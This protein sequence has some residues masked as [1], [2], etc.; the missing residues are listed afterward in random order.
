MYDQAQTLRL[1]TKGSRSKVNSY[2]I[3]DIE[4]AGVKKP[5]RFEVA[6]VYYDVII[7]DDFLRKYD[8]VVTFN[9]DEVV[10]RQPDPIQETPVKKAERAPRPRQKK[11][12]ATGHAPIKAQSKLQRNIGEAHDFDQD[13]WDD[14]DE[15][16][17]H[18][19][20]MTTMDDTLTIKTREIRELENRATIPVYPSTGQEDSPDYEPTEEDK[21]RYKMWLLFTFVKIFIGEGDKLP[22]PPMRAVMHEIPYIDK[23]DPPRP[24]RHYKVADAMMDKWVT[25]K[26]QHVEAGLWIPASTKNADPMMPILKKDGKARPVV[27]LRARNANTVKMSIPAVDADYIRS[28]IATNKYHVELDLK[29]AFQQLRIKPSDVWKTAFTSIHGVYTTPVAQQGDTNSPATLARMISYVYQ[30]LLG[31]QMEAYADNIF[32]VGNT[33]KEIRDHTIS[34]L[35]RSQVHELCFSTSSLKVCPEWVEVLGMDCQFGT[36]RMSQAHKDA[37]LTIAKPTT[38]VHLQR[39][40]GSVE[41]SSRYFPHLAEIVA[42]LTNLVGDAPWTWSAAQDIAFEETKK[43]IDDAR[44]LTVIRQEELAPRDTDPI[45]RSAPPTEPVTNPSPGKYILLQCDASSVGTSA[46][47]TYGENWWNALPVYHHSRKLTNTQLSYPTHEIELLAIFEGFQKFH[48]ILLGRKVT[49]ITENESLASFL[50]ARQMNE[51]QARVYNFISQFDFVI[52]HIESDWNKTPDMFSRQYEDDNICDSYEDPNLDDLDTEHDRDDYLLLGSRL[53]S[54]QTETLRRSSRLAQPRQTEQTKTPAVETTPKAKV[55]KPKPKKLS[56]KENAIAARLEEEGGIPTDQA[57]NLDPQHRDRTWQAATDYLNDPFFKKIVTTVDDFDRYTLSADGALWQNDEIYGDRLCIAAGTVDGR[58]VRELVLEHVHEMTVHTGSR[59]MLAHAAHHYWWPTTSADIEEYCKTCEACQVSKTGPLQTIA[60]DF[61]GPLVKAQWNGKE[62][63][64]LCNWIDTFTG[65]TISVPCEQTITAKGCA[66]LFFQSVF[67]HWGIPLQIVSD[68]D[69]RW[70]SDLWRSMFEGLG[71]TLLLS[72]SFHPQTNGRIERMHRDLNAMMR[73]IVNET[74]TNWPDQLPSSCRTENVPGWA[75]PPD[76]TAAGELID[77]AMQRRS[78]ARDTILKARGDQA[79]IANRKRKPDAQPQTAIGELFL[80]RTANFACAPDRPRK[81]TPPW[82]GPFK[83]VAFTPAT[84][85]YTLELSPRYAQ[86]RLHP[87]FHASQV[88]KWVATDE[89][90]FP[91]RLFNPKPLFPIDGVTMTDNIQTDQQMEV[92]NRDDIEYGKYGDLIGEDV[93][94]SATQPTPAPAEAVQA[95]PAPVTET[96]AD[97]PE[98]Q[99]TAPIQRSPSPDFDEPSYDKSITVASLKNREEWSEILRL[100]HR[101]APAK[102]GLGERNPPPRIKNVINI[103][104][105]GTGLRY[106]VKYS[107]NKNERSDTL[108]TTDDMVRDLWDAYHA[109]YKTPLNRWLDMHMAV[110]E[111]T[112]FE[113]LERKRAELAET[114]HLNRRQLRDQE[115]EGKQQR[116]RHDRSML[117]ISDEIKESEALLKLEEIRTRTAAA[118]LATTQLDT[119]RRELLPRSKGKGRSHPSVWVLSLPL[120]GTHSF[121]PILKPEYSLQYLF[122]DNEYDESIGPVL[123]ILL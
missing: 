98:Q 121:E 2:C 93:T 8:C 49:V 103:S 48:N 60:V 46:C 59:K 54:L 65:E 67:P 29:G 105:N 44:Q 104:R 73:Q 51:R 113:A 108:Q 118:K 33:W 56:R 39:F 87:R 36:I 112:L 41:W 99:V 52:R 76:G 89:N 26:D 32:V 100:H 25:L 97:E 85:T 106:H 20:S 79:V 81:W 21:N 95:A 5:Q 88:K 18:F 9:P 6:N 34:V 24:R 22:F 82:A 43:A 77:R 12:Q 45:H 107:D 61:Q 62:V 57:L 119:E 74:H 69:P 53:Q 71:T 86:R 101:Q 78:R 55:A 70:S 4:F 3:L 64:F 16:V 75:R 91:N 66:E 80:V 115:V 84:S 109:G 14:D 15:V 28:R 17:I 31:K 50:T 102:S 92:D 72:T 58:K 110:N 47:V 90:R 27:D 19:G 120:R 63:D 68:R 10:S 30:G 23:S 35:V 7:G 123:A 1:G 117:D 114:G 13:E 40:L 122:K 116:V 111:I 38:K 37:I 42:P 83:C 96:I 11:R 94:S